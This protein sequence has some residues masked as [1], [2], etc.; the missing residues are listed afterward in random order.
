MSLSVSSI[1]SSNTVQIR[2]KGLLFDMDG[3]LVSSLESV[4]RSWTKWALMR[5]LDPAY[6]C[7]ASRGCRAVNTIAK[8][9]PDLDAAY[10]VSI[11]ENFE[12][13]DT[14]DIAALPGVLDLLATLNRNP[15]TRDCWTVVTSAS[16]RLARRRMAA[17]RIPIPTCIVAAEQ[18]D[19]G[20]P[21]PDPFLAG[22]ALLGF[23]PQECVVFEDSSSGVQAGRA[24]G[25]TV[26]ATT[27]SHPIDSLDAAHYLV[28]DLTGIQVNAL[29]QAEGLA[30][31]FVPR[32]SQA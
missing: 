28:T 6:A 1:P 15:D 23:Q 21:H 7:E 9:R 5:G 27:F 29:P 2:C 17:G 4:E 10:E 20:K 8:L 14:D 16:A 24:A 13:E 3:I 22:A 18:V 30:L 25:C 31:S 32:P 12:L 11:L 26:V 19:K